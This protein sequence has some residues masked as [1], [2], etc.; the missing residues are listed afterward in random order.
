MSADES[1]DPSNIANYSSE[2]EFVDSTEIQPNQSY[3]SGIF[4]RTLNF[5]RNIRKPKSIFSPSTS[6]ETSEEEDLEE[7]MA[8]QNVAAMATALKDIQKLGKTNYTTWRERVLACF[9][10][11]GLLIDYDKAYADLSDPEKLISVKA[12][13][14]LKNAVDDDN[15]RLISLNKCVN[16]NE[17]WKLLKDSHL[18]KNLVALL[19]AFENVMF[20]KYERTTPMKEHLMMFK[21]TFNDMERIDQT[22]SE[23]AKV[24]FLMASLGPDFSTFK[25]MLCQLDVANLKFDDVERQLELFSANLEREN[26]SSFSSTHSAMHA[27]HQNS[28]YQNYGQLPVK[29]RMIAQNPG[30]MRRSQSSAFNPNYNSGNFHNRG[31]NRNAFRGNESNYTSRGGGMNYGQRG[32]MRQ[33]FSFNRNQFNQNQSGPS[34][35]Y[36]F[37][38]HQAEFP[39]QHSTCYEANQPQF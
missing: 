1:D 29:L 39:P 19:D 14:H 11:G 16:G 4:N 27:A 8:N 38:G 35:N 33:N 5:T 36:Q 21:N 9:E 34:R 22:Q 10:V 7:V 12:L 17:A 30:F 20:K 15:L 32:N 6:E 26:N 23:L 13:A 24:A 3:I 2:V 25:Q 37:R 31:G 18:K 28:T